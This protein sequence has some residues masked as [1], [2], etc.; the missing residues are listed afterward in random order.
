M[1]KT[2]SCHLKNFQGQSRRSTRDYAQHKPRSESLGERGMEDVP[3][4]LVFSS[5]LTT[6][7]A[8]YA[9]YGSWEEMTEKPGCVSAHTNIVRKWDDL[10]D[11]KY[12]KSHTDKRVKREL[13]GAVCQRRWLRKAPMKKIKGKYV[14]YSLDTGF[15]ETG[16]SDE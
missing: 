9:S 6:C 7:F 14:S 16:S 3:Q 8:D 13:Q 10:I 12:L 4:L 2:Y 1:S 5:L 11:N 15:L